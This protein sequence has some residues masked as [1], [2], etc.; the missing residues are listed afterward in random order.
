[1]I[2]HFKR[3]L[4]IIGILSIFI[5]FS[6]EIGASR[7]FQLNITDPSFESSVSI[8]RSGT[9]PPEITA[10]LAGDQPDQVIHAFSLL[11]WERANAVAFLQDQ[12]LL[13]I[14]TSLGIRFYELETFEET[15]WIP[16]D[17]W[18]RSIALSPDGTILAAGLFDHKIHLY[19]TSDGSLIEILAGHTNWVRTVVFSVDGNTLISVSDDETIRFW[20]VSSG[21]NL[22]NLNSHA[23]GARSIALSPD[24]TILAVGAK[25]GSI[26]LL[27]VE[28]GALLN[29]LAG[30]TDWVRTLTFSHNGELLASGAFDAT[31]RLWRVSD[32]A[33]LHELKGHTASVLSVAFTPDNRTIATGSVDATVRLWDV[34][35]G[36]LQSILMGHTDFIYGVAISADGSLLAS[37]A[38]DGVVLLWDLSQTYPHS[39]MQ[40]QDKSSDCRVCHH[41]VSTTIP[42][43]VLEVRCQVCHTGGAVLNW[44]PVFPRQTV[45][46]FSTQGYTVL[47]DKAG[48]P[49]PDSTLSVMIVA[50]GNGETIYT[51]PEFVTPLKVLGRVVSMDHD[52]SEIAVTL[53]VWSGMDRVAALPAELNPDGSFSFDLGMNPDGVDPV[54]SSEQIDAGSIVCDSCHSKYE[55]DFYLPEGELHLILSAT[56]PGDAQA[57]DDRWITVDVSKVGTLE[58]TVVDSETGAPL[59]GISVQA[60]TRLYEW[61]PRSSSTITAQ[62]GIATLNLELLTQASTTY[63]I[64]VPRQV[65][66]GIYYESWQTVEVTYHPDASAMQSVIIQVESQQAEIRGR[67]EGLQN[68]NT[69]PVSV[70]AVRL[71]AGPVYKTE[72]AR[73]VFTFTEMPIAEYLVFPDANG[74][75]MEKFKN[76][77]QKVDLYALPIFDLNL[78]V[79]QSKGNPIKGEIADLDTN[80]LPFAWLEQRNSDVYPVDL[81]SGAWA[82]NQASEEPQTITVGVPGYYSQEIFLQAEDSS[83]RNM[84]ISLKK[85]PETVVQSWG[86]G[87]IVLPPETKAVFKDDTLTVERG[88][89]WGNNANEQVLNIA[90]AETEIHWFSGRFALSHLPG[91]TTWFYLLD[92]TAKV[93]SKVSGEMMTV[94]PGMIV[95]IQ[96]NGK[97]SAIS[98]DPTVFA[99]LNQVDEMPISPVW[100]PTLSARIQNRLAKLGITTVQIVTYVTYALVLISIVAIPVGKI[101]L[102]VIEQKTSKREGI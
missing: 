9:I 99:V 81:K 55:P 41:P 43:P 76:H 88:W 95:A 46:P 6:G 40:V 38:D 50:P 61:R 51:K 98:Y 22:F 53:E 29:T 35:S 85:R 56:G 101:C 83:D 102:R 36:K 49:N 7:A 70:W 26:L 37:G 8:I 86:T 31:A 60:A 65:A 59:S 84:V 93:S 23:W 97:L 34:D 82:V 94:Q 64:S 72:A 18:V 12:D 28:D 27:R 16:T 14:G 62:N 2:T 74:I 4:G 33:M 30:H 13:I 89:V 11:P 52:I 45:A 48:V 68:S 10:I 42:P 79:P 32:G 54:R 100:E 44:C 73:G 80:W 3:F 91:Q 75:P 71:P 5:F 19:N 63:L 78:S 58:V 21:N 47:S 92:G 87:G 39:D 77:I 15:R 96:D 20:N 90:V 69:D 57:R 66:N 24:G 1:M 67:L 17:S 25:D